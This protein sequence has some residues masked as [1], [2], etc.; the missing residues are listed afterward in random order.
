MIKINYSL[1]EESDLEK[2]YFDIFMSTKFNEIGRAH[3]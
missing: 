1:N 2:E 3:V